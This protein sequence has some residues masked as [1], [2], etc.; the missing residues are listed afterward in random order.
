MCRNL[1]LSELIQSLRKIFRIFLSGGGGVATTTGILV[2]IGF[3][4]V[5]LK[6][7]AAAAAC[8]RLDSKKI[9]GRCGF[10]YNVVYT[11]VAVFQIRAYAA[12]AAGR[13]ELI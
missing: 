9:P 6:N 7:A 12:A 2:G 5:W 4:K 10:M 1:P 13:S 3:T 8:A 11:S